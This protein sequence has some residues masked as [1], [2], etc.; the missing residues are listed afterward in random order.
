ML[1]E[2]QARKHEQ[3]YSNEHRKLLG[4]H[5]T[6]EPIVDYIVKR[7]LLPLLESPDYQEIKVLDPACGSG[8]FLLKS[9]DILAQHWRNTFGSFGPKQAKHILSNS[10]YGIDIDEQA[11]LTTRKHLLEKAALVESDVPLL[12]ENIIVRDA[13]TLKLPVTQF[14][15]SYQKHSF[16]CI[17][18]NPPYIRIQNTSQEKRDYYTS[19]YVTASGRF[20]ISTLFLELSEYLLKEQGRIGFI[21]SN[22]IL[23]TS[24]AKKLRAFLLSRF[25][26]EE[27]VDLSDTKLFEAAVLPMILVA[28]RS[29]HNNNHIAY[30]SITELHN[31][32]T[33][34]I[35][36]DNLLGL[37][38]SSPIP[39]EGNVSTVNK[40]FQ[41]QRFYANRPSLRANVW[42]FH[43][44]RENRL[45]AKLRHNS[46]N[47][48][49]DL[50]EKISVGL[51]TTADQVF[52]K[53][54]I[55]DFI[56]LKG[57]ESD[58]VY[59][60]LESHNIERWKYSW[61][62]RLDLFVLYPHVEQN[63]KVVPVDLDRYPNTKHYLEINRPQLEGR[64]YLTES[65]RR[66]YEIWVHQS[67][68]DFRQR[69]IITPDISSHNRF[70]LDDKSFFVNGTCFYIILKDKSDDSYF[71]ILGL[72]NSKVI[73]YFHKTTS[74]NS[75]YAKRFRY[76][77]SYLGS[78]PIAN[79]LF[80]SPE[81]SSA[82]VNN[83]SRL[84]KTSTDKER[85]ELEKENDHLCYQL[86]DLT[87]DEIQEIE[88]TLSVH[89]LN[90][91]IK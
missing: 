13:L 25:S 1:I 23:S 19:T 33:E 34:T 47:T 88:S 46:F 70:A 31:H 26:I 15:R 62:S 22:K 90:K 53:P 36:T 78:Y 52:V 77:S 61:D 84:L 86:F 67:P 8:L 49:N 2:T 5:Y 66:W 79:K 85:I 76:W 12:N 6:P 65:G 71:S 35:Q 24:G 42:T 89:S 18:G 29:R 80:N 68:D 81:L 44:E 41:I 69:K 64:T 59:P 4:T 27:I 14:G 83:V 50:S 72:L 10:L 55:K 28:T 51:K 7:S 43:N 38:S 32:V 74:G 17:I 11:V 57:L 82:I 87:E 30:S 21:V 91:S 9:F 37:I 20:D 40:V 56:E 48:L 54:M 39:F 60:V 3:T 16:H 63:G 73:E 75:L 58:L 45:L